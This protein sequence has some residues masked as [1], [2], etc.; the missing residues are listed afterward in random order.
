MFYSFSLSRNV[1]A[2]SFYFKKNVVYLIEVFTWIDGGV[3]VLQEV[4]R[5]VDA[6]ASHTHGLPLDDLK[7]IDN[8][9]NELFF[10]LWDLTVGMSKLLK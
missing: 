2:T 1:N 5:S 3:D 8:K 9:N 4:E 10:S 7:F 6:V